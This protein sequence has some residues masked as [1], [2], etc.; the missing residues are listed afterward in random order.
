MI[1]THHS[2]SQLLAKQS[3]RS[4]GQKLAYPIKCQ[5]LLESIIID[6]ST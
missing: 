6:I 3:S 2:F 5:P 4:K 1:N